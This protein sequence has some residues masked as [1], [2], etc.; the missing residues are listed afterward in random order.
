[1][2]QKSQRK[3]MIQIKRKAIVK[4]AITFIALLVI[5]FG[6]FIFIERVPEGKVAVVYAPSGGAKKVLNPGWHMI[7]LFQK[8]QQYPTR[9]AIVQSELSVTTSDGKKITLP[10]RYEM[11]VDKSKVLDIFKELGSQDIEQIQ[12]GYLY[13]RLFQSARSVVSEYSVLDIFGQKTTE[14]SA[15][16]TEQMYDK[17]KGLGFIIADVTL[18]NPEVDDETQKAIDARVKSAQENELKKQELE[19]EKIESA[20][21]EEKARGDKQK[22]II[23]AEG[24]AEANEKI[25]DSITPNLLKL[26]EMEARLEHGWITIQ[27][28]NG[29][30][31]DQPE[32]K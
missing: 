8:T 20:K 23:D 10:A 30:I 32:D 7:G 5:V 16:V 12:E 27:G 19:N 22:R 18:G 11:K 14:A 4:L 29:I 21:K 15:K 13:Q 1:M 28:S 6:L 25:N 9:I 2:K 31:V 17:S 24:V 3:E 26:K